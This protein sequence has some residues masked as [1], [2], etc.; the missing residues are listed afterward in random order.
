MVGRLARDGAYS[1]G[2]REMIS[3]WPA[4]MDACPGAELW[5]VG[6]GDLR[7]EL[8]RWRDDVFDR[9]SVPT[10]QHGAVRFFGEVTTSGGTSS[11]PLPAVWHFPVVARASASST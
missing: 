7:K 8:E 3:V 5:I 2:H 4:V 9:H 1:K 11:S 6:D 10:T